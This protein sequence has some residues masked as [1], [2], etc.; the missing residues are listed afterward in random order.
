M[1]KLKRKGRNL[2]SKEHSERKTQHI[3]PAV[4]T[5]FVFRVFVSSVVVG[6]N[7]VCHALG[8]VVQP[9]VVTEVEKDA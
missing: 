7:I 9:H 5:D 6:R 8:D 1:N 3:V 4:K 2:L